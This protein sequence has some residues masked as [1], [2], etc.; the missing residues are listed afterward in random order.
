M[1]D[2]WVASKSA[3]SPRL[4]DAAITPDK[5]SSC[6]TVGS[7]DGITGWLHTSPPIST[8][9]QVSSFNRVGNAPRFREVKIGA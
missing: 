9:A 4:V 6:W 8:H 7:F 3:F 5:P 1:P 2:S